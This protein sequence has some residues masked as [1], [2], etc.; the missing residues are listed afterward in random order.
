MSDKGKPGTAVVSRKISE[1][2]VEITVSIITSVHMIRDLSRAGL[3]RHGIVVHFYA[4]IFERLVNHR[5]KHV[6]HF[7]YSVLFDDRAA[8]VIGQR[9]GRAV[10]VVYLFGEMRRYEIAAIRE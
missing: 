2:G 3:G 9:F 7:S 8:L 6:R 1:E 5:D 4:S 10:N